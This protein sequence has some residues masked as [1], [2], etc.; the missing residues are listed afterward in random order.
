MNIIAPR[1]KLLEEFTCGHGVFIVEVHVA[2]RVEE[3]IEGAY[4]NAEMFVENIGEIF[5]VEGG[6]QLILGIA[7]ANIFKL[8]NGVFDFLGPVLAASFNHA[9][10]K[11]M[12]GNIK[13][14]AALA[15]EPCGQAT[16]LIMVFN[17]KH[18]MTGFGQ[19][20]SRGESTES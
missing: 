16:E 14:M 7:K 8:H 15:G 2:N 18:L 13:N 20:V 17:N 11:T 19:L 3:L 12:Q 9:I 6:L 4:F 5:T 1:E 10:R